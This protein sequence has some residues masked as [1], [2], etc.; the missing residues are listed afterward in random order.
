[1]RV[2][3]VL[4]VIVLPLCLDFVVWCRVVLWC[5]VCIACGKGGEVILHVKN[6]SGSQAECVARKRFKGGRGGARETGVLDRESKRPDS[7]K[8][9][10]EI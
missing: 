10:L 8:R 9:G 6:G 3:V 7:N 2:V 5:G 4:V 1:M